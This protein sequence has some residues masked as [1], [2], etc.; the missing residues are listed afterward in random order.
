MTAKAYIFFDNSNI[1]LSGK[2]IAEMR[3]GIGAKGPF[4]LQ[5]DRLIELAA[6]GRPIG[7]AWASGS[8]ASDRSNPIWKTL[9]DRG[10]Q[11]EVYERGA[12]SGGEQAVDQ[13]LQV[14]MLRLGYQEPQVAVI[15]TGD[16]SGHEDGAGFLNDAKLMASNGWGIEVLSWKHSCNAALRA[17]AESR[18]VFVPLDDYY[19]QVTFLEFGRMSKP[20]D[21]SQ[22]R[23]AT[24]GVSI[25]SRSH[26]DGRRESAAKLEQLEAQLAELRCKSMK[27]DRYRAKMQRRNASGTR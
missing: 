11:V 7:G 24:P 21:L 6:A 27:T 4:R 22:R 9:H 2:T 16:G 12:Q 23:T 5:L 26:E 8:T 1:F 15:L 10:V 17:W 13:S 19:D 14:H 18:G 3:E 20:L 25:Q